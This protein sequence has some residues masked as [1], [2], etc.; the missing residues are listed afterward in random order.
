[1]KRNED[2]LFHQLSYALVSMN[3]LDSKQKTMLETSF[4]KVKSQLKGSFSFTLADPKEYLAKAVI[5]L[6]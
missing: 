1:M 6:I 2:L 3:T 5:K 4:D